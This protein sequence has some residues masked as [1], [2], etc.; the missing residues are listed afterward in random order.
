[1][2]RLL[3]L[4]AVL[5]MA[6]GVAACGLSASPDPVP[7]PDSVPIPD[8]APVPDPYAFTSADVGF[9][10]GSDQ[11]HQVDRI[12]AMDAY[13]GDKKPIVRIDLYWH[14]V[15]PSRDRAPDWTK[16]DRVID[17][18][19]EQGVRVLLVLDY[20]TKWAN[21]GRGTN[22]FPTDDAAWAVIVR[23]AV[24]HFGPKVQAY[25]VW[26]EPNLKQFGNYGDNSVDVRAGRYWQLAKIAYQEVHAG[27]PQ[28]VVLAGGSTGGDTY[29]GAKGVWHGHDEASVWLEWAYKHGMGGYLDAVAYHPYADF[30]GGNLP[31]FARDPCQANGRHQWHRF[32]SWFGPDDPKCGGLSALREV[33]VRHGDA[34]KQIWGTEMGFP[35]DGWR[36]PQTPEHVRDALE[37]GVRMWRSRPYAGPLFVYSFQDVPKTVKRCKADPHDMQCHFGLRDSYGNPKEPMYSDVRAALIGDDWLP[38]LAPG[39]SLFR[40]AEVRSANGQFT[41]NMQ[42]DGNLVLYDLRSGAPAPI[43]VR[44]DRRGYRLANRHDGNLVLYDYANRPLWVSGTSGRGVSTMRLQDDGSLV[45]GSGA[46]EYWSAAPGATAY[47]HV[48]GAQAGT[49]P[50]EGSMYTSVGATQA[51][52]SIY[53]DINKTVNPGDTVCADAHVVTEGEATDGGGTFALFLTGGAAETSNKSVVKLPNGNSWTP[54][55]TCVTATSGHSAVRVQFYPAVGG[56]TVGVDAVDVHL[57][58]AKNGGFNSGFDS[59]TDAPGSQHAIYGPGVTGNNPYEGTGFAATNT[60]VVGGGIYQDVNVAVKA[61]DT[62]CGSA[63]VASQGTTAGAGGSFAIWL[64]GGSQQN[65][66]AA[67]A[68]L[69]GGNDWTPVSTCVTATTAYS[70]LRLQ[71]YPDP[72]TGAVVIDAVD[73]R[74]S[75]A[76]NGGFNTKGDCVVC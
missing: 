35:S 45:F 33:M 2:R 23:Q 5:I 34:G 62:F 17:A 71:F 37:E 75:L 53:Q 1:M 47:Q 76:V 36:D 52:G 13:V 70:K 14:L 8:A 64:I 69:P 19:Y 44:G 38:T 50:Y 57:S 15:Q 24:A 40:G 63:Q 28:C 30:E 31:S 16:L 60:T 21:G 55:S 27:C 72:N 26:N 74:Q 41:L 51:G 65:S 39:R 10:D 20:S 12:A 32:W 68:N 9:I 25:E 66:V 54:L 29:E 43:W 59:W 61:G 67:Y 42:A 11:E 22:Y 46:G 56:P 49:D 73:V 7:T 18:A 6:L 48:A 4:I 3:A 58:V